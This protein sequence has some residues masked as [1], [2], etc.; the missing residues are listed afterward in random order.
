MSNGNAVKS[1]IRGRVLARVLAE[2]LD[3]ITG[4]LPVET[5]TITITCNDQTGHSDASNICGEDG[6]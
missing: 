2:D 6:D 1:P 3:K 5:G 4:G